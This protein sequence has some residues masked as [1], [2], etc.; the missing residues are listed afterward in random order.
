[1]NCVNG[2]RSYCL[3]CFIVRESRRVRVVRTYKEMMKL[4]LVEKYSKDIE[5]TDNRVFKLVWILW[6]L[7]EIS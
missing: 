3:C 7:G 5:S 4:R 6:R 2:D 1:M